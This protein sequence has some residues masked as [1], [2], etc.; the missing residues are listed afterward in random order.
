M[1]FPAQLQRQ[2]KNCKF[3]ALCYTGYNAAAK[4]QIISEENF[5]ASNSSEKRTKN[6]CPSRLGQNCEFSSLAFG[7]IE[8]TKISFRD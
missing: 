5:R 6:F 2:K 3:L 8:D 7:R 1:I 4:G